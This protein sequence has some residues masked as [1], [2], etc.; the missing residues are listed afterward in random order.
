LRDVGPRHKI[1]LTP[2]DAARQGDDLMRRR[3]TRNVIAIVG[4]GLVLGL[5]GWLDTVVVEGIR[6]RSS[7]TFEGS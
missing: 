2:L 7:Q 3:S 1:R 6:Q 5:A 4:A